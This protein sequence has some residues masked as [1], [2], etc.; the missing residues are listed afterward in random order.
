ML[1]DMAS[2][3]T[4]TLAELADY[5]RW[6]VDGRYVYYSTLF[7]TTNGKSGGVHRWKMANNTTEMVTGSPDFPLAGVWGVSYSLTPEGDLLL[8]RDLSTRDLYALELVLP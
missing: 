2:R 6:S 8:L 5:P 4:R 7:F 1:Y 3:T